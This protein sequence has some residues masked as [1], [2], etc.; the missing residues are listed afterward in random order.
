ML[1]QEGGRKGKEEQDELK[2]KEE[3][4]NDAASVGNDDSEDFHTQ[5]QLR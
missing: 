3:Q 1:G 5:H 2:G 4:M